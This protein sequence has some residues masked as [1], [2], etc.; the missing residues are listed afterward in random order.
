MNRGPLANECIQQMKNRDLRQACKDR[1]LLTGGR[2]AELKSRLVEYS[3]TYH[4]RENNNEDAEV[5]NQNSDNTK[6]AGSLV[7]AATPGS[8][9]E[10]S[11][12]ES[13]GDVDGSSSNSAGSQLDASSNSPVGS[14]AQ[15]TT[16]QKR[17]S[18]T[19]NLSSIKKTPPS[20]KR[21]TSFDVDEDFLSSDDLMEKMGVP[22]DMELIISDTDFKPT[23]I[24]TK[25]RFVLRGIMA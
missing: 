16:P 23:M 17:T 4:A 10:F 13:D 12:H 9:E 3:R 15:T 25:K 19:S 24:Q 7:G 21:K 2:N 8:D 18:K 20:K 1:K 11:S 5:G 22:I 14:S 6:E